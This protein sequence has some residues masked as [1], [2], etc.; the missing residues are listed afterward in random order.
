MTTKQ[1]ADAI[2]WLHLIWILFGIFSL[3]LIFV[4]SWWSNVALIFATVTVMSWIVFRGCWFLQMENQLRNAYNPN[5]AFE[6]EAFIQHYLK[7][8]FGINSSRTTVRIFLYSY[9]SIM[10]YFAIA[11]LLPLG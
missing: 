4:V 3:P 1:K 8:Y 6:E 2:A 10:I 7:K 5:E 9:M 11:R